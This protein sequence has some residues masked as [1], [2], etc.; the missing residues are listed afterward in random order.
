[1]I[2]DLERRHGVLP[3][4]RLLRLGWTHHAIA[5]ATASETLVRLRSGWL[6]RPDADVR[7]VAAVRAGGC[8]ACADALRVHGVWVPER[9]GRDHVRRSRRARTRGPAGCRPYGATT[10]I[11]GAVDD[12]DMAFRCLLRCGEAEDVTVVADSILHLRLASAAEL[13]AWSVDAPSRMRRA[14]ER[15]DASESGLESILRLRLRSRN[16]RVRTQV[17]IEGMRVDLLVGDVLVVE[18]DGGEH[19]ASW[20]A[21]A[22]D[23]ARDRR[24]TTLGFVVV[25]LTYGQIVDDWEAVEADLLSLVRR[26]AHRARGEMRT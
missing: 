25:R 15:V 7:V 1:M 26:R 23:R 8:L 6:A 21:Q 2:H 24:L 13:E 4:A 12:V 20:T 5:E 19:H 9:L 10:P 14:L 22:A 3:T 16:V 17:W 18:C 11:D